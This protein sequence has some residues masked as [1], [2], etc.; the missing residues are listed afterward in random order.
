MQA[1]LHLNPE[2]RASCSELLRLPYL[3]NVEA[4]FSEDFLAAQ[5]GC[6]LAHTLASTHVLIIS[7]AVQDFPESV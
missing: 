3:S 5:V 4:S 1:C 7:T 6:T 2:N